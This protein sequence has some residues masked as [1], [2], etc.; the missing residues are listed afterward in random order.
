MKVIDVLEALKYGELANSH[1]SESLLDVSA[2][3]S[4][5]YNYINRAIGD[6]NTEFNLN[7]SEFLLTLQDN[8]AKYTI[9]SVKALKILHAFRS[10]GLELSL[11]ST[12]DPLLSVYIPSFNRIEYYGLNNA[13]ATVSDYLSIIYLKE[14]DKVVSD[15][16]EI[17]LTEAFLECIS[18]YVGYLA[19]HS[20]GIADNTVAMGFKVN[21]LESIAKVKRLGLIPDVNG[22]TFWLTSKGFI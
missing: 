14:F 5:V 4:Q 12:I 1:L 13:S 18:S 16:D 3:R 8:V 19:Q 17:P 9:T 11:N 21:Y 20:L 10:D 7:E 6:I 22:K 15:L 2:D